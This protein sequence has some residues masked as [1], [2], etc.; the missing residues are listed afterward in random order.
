MRVDV[1]TESTTAPPSA[2]LRGVELRVTQ[3]RLEALERHPHAGTDVIN[4][5]HVVC[6]S[7]GD[8]VDID[9]ATCAGSTEPQPDLTAPRTTEMRTHHA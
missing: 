1:M 7:R 9:R 3:R 2:L 5:H 8:V 4:H 6:R